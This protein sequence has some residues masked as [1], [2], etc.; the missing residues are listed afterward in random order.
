VSARWIGAVLLAA[1]GLTACAGSGSDEG[2]E[3]SPPP[4]PPQAAPPPPPPQ[5]PPPPPP[6]PATTETTGDGSVELVAMPPGAA[7]RC[8]ASR[9][10][11]P[12]CPRL[13]PEAPYDELPEVYVVQLIPG[14]PGGPELFNLQ[15]GAESPGRPGRNRP[16]R[17]SHV[18]VA[19]G[20]EGEALQGIRARPLRD[21]DWSGRQGTLVRAAPYPRGGLH[22]SHLVFRW[23]EGRREYAVSLHTWAPLAETVATLRAVVASIPPP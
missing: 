14:G 17:L 11:R 12:A 21:V 20:T 8:R 15:W 6:S 7:R 5:A 1:V 16:P 18:V 22:G 10:V 19:A 13:V 4:S 23:Q 3:P 9:L 2:G